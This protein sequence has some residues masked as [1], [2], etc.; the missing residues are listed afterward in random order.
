MHMRSDMHKIVVER[1]R[2]G[3]T[4][5]SRKWGKRLPYIPDSD[6]EDEIRFASSAR[7]RQYGWSCKSLSDVLRPLKGYLRKNLGRPWDKVY[8][9]LRQGLDVRKVTGMH[10]FDHV[11]WM[12]ATDCYVDE[13]GIVRQVVK[14]REVAG[15][16]VHPKT[17]LL[18]GA[19]RSSRRRR[20]KENLPTRQIGEVRLDRNTSYRLLDG[21]W[22]WVKHEFARLGPGSQ[23]NRRDPAEHCR[24]G[25]TGPQHITVWPMVKTTL[26]RRCKR[27]SLPS[28][29]VP[30]RRRKLC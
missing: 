26:R 6:Y 4:E 15:F 17:G 22:Y 9:E 3:S 11:K 1:E 23:L 2:G 30:V 14:D 25:E 16:F 18:C 10:I 24:V 29:H 8:S 28:G 7:R 21:E 12:V 27:T 19:A 5:K 13:K 20:K